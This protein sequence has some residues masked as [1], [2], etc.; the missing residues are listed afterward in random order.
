MKVPSGRKFVKMVLTRSTK[1]L[2]EEY[3]SHMKKIAD[4]RHAAAVLQWD[5]ETYLPPKGA[6]F[7]GQQMATLSEIAHEWS[8]DP[9]LGDLMT[10]LKGRGDL[11]EPGGK[12]ISLSLEDYTRQKKFTPAFIRLLSETTSRCFHTWIKARKDNSFT[13]FRDDLDKMIQLKKQE[14][15]MAGY[16]SCPPL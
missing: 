3:T 11:D 16:D 15:E 10:E 2:Y 1:E 14:A 12:N 7:R 8:I 9:K 5:E 4:V 6:S 13:I